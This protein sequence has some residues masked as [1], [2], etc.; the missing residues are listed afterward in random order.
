MT[1]APSRMP[2]TAMHWGTYRAETRDGRLCALHPF[3]MDVDPSPI[4]G[5]YIGALDADSRITTPMVRQ[6]WLQDPQGRDRDRRGADSFV[7]V[8]WDEA[9]RLVAQELLRVR[10]THGCGAI[11]A[12]S[13]GWASAGRFHH[14]QG[15]LRRFLNLLGGHVGSKNTYSLAAG[16]VITKYAVG[17][18]GVAA[19]GT[20]DWR[21]LVAHC[22][23]LVAFG[24]MRV[25]N[26]QISQGGC[27]RHRQREAMTQAHAKG[28]NFVNVS[29]LRD[30]VLA[31]LSA[32]WLPIRPSTD[33]ALVLG[34]CHTLLQDG[35]HDA[36]FLDR[37]TVGFDRFADYLTGKTDGVVK[38][39]DW[40]SGLC[41]IGA[42][43]IVELAR[44]MATT[45]TMIS[46]SWSLTR[47][48]HGEQPFWAVIAL[49]SMLGQIGL[50][51]GGFGLGYS[52]VNSMGLENTAL[53]FPP[54]PQGQNPVTDFIPVAR[55]AEMLERPGET[56]EY[57]GE[58]RTYPDA[59]LVWWAGGNPFHHHQDLG[60]L[61]AAWRRPDTVIVN[62][63]CWTATAQHADI[64]LPCTTPL[65]RRDLCMGGRDPFVIAM[66]Q[67]AQPPEGARDDY[68]IF[69]GMARAM[70]LEAAFTEGRSAGDWQRWMYEAGREA[71]GQRGIDLP[72]YD[73]LRE[74]GWH[75]VDPPEKPQVL[76][77]AFRAD[78]E[79]NP[80]PTPS[81]RIEIW[82]DRI[83][84][85]AYEDCPPH[86][87]W[88]EPFEWLGKCQPDE[89]HLISN[90]PTTKLHSQL[91]QGVFSQSAKVNG[92]EPVR[93][94]PD[95]AAA[96]GIVDGDLVELYNT[97][98]RCLCAA[99]LDDRLRPGVVQVS[100]GAWYAPDPHAPDLCRNGNPNVLTR[101]KGTSRL[102]QGCSAHTCLV[103]IRKVQSEG[104]L[105]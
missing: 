85:F 71:A 57:D 72:D 17:G 15:H 55:V 38:S 10:Q 93:I 2:L 102:S 98:G 84:S 54:M 8:S 40:A 62:D 101:D 65:E 25:T 46:A 19:G 78:P 20:T 74:R 7:A 11:Y 39:A 43:R 79:A 53:R 91:D 6:G 41:D 100:T 63:W 58:T 31:E 61:R 26:G 92:Y 52:A 21:T 60:R 81:G 27:G 50:P 51:G 12:G 73:S 30:D 47:Q 70:G 56:Y 32:D 89:L 49:A 24:G 104:K 90:Q 48:D 86:P 97:R 33:T 103:R 22:E 3:E 35:L 68:D 64:V 105:S 28:V 37:Y 87:S 76:L 18:F 1:D 69:A 14:P 9:E 80:L 77:Q 44:R 59:R 23:T 16:E 82:S 34:L 83:A 95:D 4:A 96:R 88:L 45:R 67:V 42:D 66:E 36:A 75:R 99:V 5:G 29:P 13:Y 94:N